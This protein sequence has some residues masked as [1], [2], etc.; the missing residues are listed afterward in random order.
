MICGILK[1]N[2]VPSPASDS[3]LIEPL[4]LSMDSFTIYNPNPEPGWFSVA[5]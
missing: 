1:M 2:Q 3:I 4:S 5:L